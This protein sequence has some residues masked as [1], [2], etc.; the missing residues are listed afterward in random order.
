MHY[1]KESAEKIEIYRECT[2]Q[3]LKDFLR[4]R[5]TDEELVYIEFAIL[6]KYNISLEKDV[7]TTKL[8]QK[9]T[10]T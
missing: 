2:M 4:D 8:P 7:Y 6:Q 1:C 10:T 3:V 5:I 9:S